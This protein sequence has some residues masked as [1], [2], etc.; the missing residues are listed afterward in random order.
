MREALERT[1]EEKLVGY[2]LRGPRAGREILV[3]LRDAGQGSFDEHHIIW[4]K[5]SG[6]A[7]KSNTSRE[8]RLLCKV[9]RLLIQF[10]QVDI[11]NSAGAE[12]LVRRLLQLEAATRRNPRQP[13]FEGLDII[14]DSAVDDHGAAVVSA[15][16]TWVADQQKNE[17]VSLKAARQWRDEQSTRDKLGKKGKKDE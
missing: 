12:M 8:H 13:D 17:A 2:P 15:F 7:E 9:L 5:Q 10:D 1:I 6:V 11:S 4:N 16:S 3:A 14:L